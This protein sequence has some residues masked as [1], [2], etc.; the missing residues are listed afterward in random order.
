MLAE[1]ALKGQRGHPILASDA[2][3]RSANT[4]KSCKSPRFE[5][6]LTAYKCITGVLQYAGASASAFVIALVPRASWRERHQP[7]PELQTQ[8][9]QAERRLQRGRRN[10]QIPDLL[11]PKTRPGRQPEQR[12]PVHDQARAGA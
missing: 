3:A 10:P 11:D 4:S 6:Q 8:Q 7:F 9:P 12:Q 2:R 5:R 1:T